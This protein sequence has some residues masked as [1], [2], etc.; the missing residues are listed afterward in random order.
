MERDVLD[1]D[2]IAQ[3]E[4]ERF[5]RRSLRFF[6]LPDGMTKVIGLLD[7]E[8]AALVSDAFDRVSSP[9]R[10]GPRF[11]D[12]AERSREQ[13]ILDDPR[14]TEQL[15]HDAFVEMVQVATR[16]DRGAIFGI[17]A[18]AVRVH[19]RG[20][21]LARRRGAG[22]VEGQSDAVSIETV[23]RHVCESGVIPIGFD[24]DGQAVNVGREQR[25][26]TTRQRVGLAAR[27][28]G[29]RFAGCDRPPSWCE[30]HHI[31]QWARDGGATDLADGVL[32]CRFHHMYVH[33]HGWRISREGAEYFAVPPP[34]AGR[35]RERIALPPKMRV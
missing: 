27:D 13:R 22:R 15:L 24:D 31:D 17:K 29:C 6:P 21:A 28:G 32:L 3:R 30:A 7:P 35:P 18:P 5:E 26:F 34:Q 2:G 10:H 16:A 11:V 19:V 12:P 4:H 23:E 1:L 8:S 14:S 9:R 25:L 20:E 33:N